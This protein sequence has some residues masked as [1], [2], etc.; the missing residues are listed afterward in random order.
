MKK[1]CLAAQRPLGFIIAY[2][3]ARSGCLISLT[4]VYREKYPAHGVPERE[5]RAAGGVGGSAPDGPAGRNAPVSPRRER[6]QSPPYS[7][8]AR[9]PPLPGQQGGSRG[10]KSARF[11]RTGVEPRRVAS[12]SSRRRTLDGTGGPFFIRRGGALPHLMRRFPGAAAR[13]PLC[14]AK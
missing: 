12:V 11:P 14:I 3:A 10:V 7:I 8:F 4:D 6:R 5:R 9:K 1:S 2:L 13:V